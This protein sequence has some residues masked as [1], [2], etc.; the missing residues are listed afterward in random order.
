MISLLNS[1]LEMTSNFSNRRKITRLTKLAATKALH[2]Y[3]VLQ[4]VHSPDIIKA[5][6]RDIPD[7][8]TKVQLNTRRHEDKEL[9]RKRAHEVEVMQGT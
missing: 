7:R 6:T 3:M 2:V 4:A 5:A 9:Q 8:R 1:E